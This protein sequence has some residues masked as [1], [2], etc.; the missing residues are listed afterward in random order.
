MI[1]LRHAN[2][3]FFLSL[4]RLSRPTSHESRTSNLFDQREI[5]QKEVL[6]AIRANEFLHLLK[7]QLLLLRFR[8]SI[9]CTAVRIG[10]RRGDRN[11]RVLL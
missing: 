7:D 1:S 3:I 2:P 9:C 4:F 10:V 8:R 5:Q 6:F 11:F